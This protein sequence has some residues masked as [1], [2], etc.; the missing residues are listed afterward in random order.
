MLTI[1]KIL[2]LNNKIIIKKTIIIKLSFKNFAIVYF[3]DRQKKFSLNKK[4]P[5]N[6]IIF[7]N[8]TFLYLFLLFL[9]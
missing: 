5:C 9:L 2:Y 6:L 7:Y 4:I 8:I 1:F 3:L